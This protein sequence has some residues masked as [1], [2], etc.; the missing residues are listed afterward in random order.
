M[1]PG[2]RQRPRQAVLLRQLLAGQ[3]RDSG[4][5]PGLDHRPRERAAPAGRLLR[6]AQAA[7][8]GAVPDLRS[9]DDAAGSDQP[10]ADDPRSVPEQHHSAR[11]HLQRRTARYKNPLMGLYSKMVPKPNQNFVENGQQP[12][13]NFYQGGQP[14]SPKSQQYGFRLDF[15]ASAKDRFFF[16]TSGITFLEYVSD[17]TYLA[18]DPALR[19]HSAD[20]SRY[21]WSYTGTWTRAMGNDACSIP[22]SRQTASTRSTSSAGSS[23]Y[24][25]TDVGLPSYLDEFCSTSGGCTLPRR[26]AHRRLSAVRRRAVGRRHRHAYAGAIG[27]YLGEGRATRCTAAIDVRRAQR[28]RTG[29][30]NRSGQLDVR[31]HL[32]AAVQRREPR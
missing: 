9:A 24:K 12:T 3:R 17:W 28:D 10:G 18:Q 23:K 7:Q 4:Q 27:D 15:N 14:D 11:S 6:P 25:P 2:R 8:P 22:R 20:R 21:Q 26:S 5:D 13:G 31:S 1:I 30:G 19:I 29:G 16:R 32:H